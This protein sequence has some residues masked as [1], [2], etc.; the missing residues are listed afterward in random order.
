MDIELINKLS[1]ARELIGE[2]DISLTQ[3]K[4]VADYAGLSLEEVKN[5][6]PDGK[7]ISV[8]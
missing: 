3:L 4:A 2:N 7:F 1:V 5:A 8:S 6:V